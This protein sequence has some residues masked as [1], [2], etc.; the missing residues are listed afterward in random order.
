VIVCARPSV[1]LGFTVLLPATRRSS[2]LQSKNLS[3]ASRICAKSG[4]SSF[5]DDGGRDIV[6]D[7]TFTPSVEVRE[8]IGADDDDDDEAA[9]L[10]YAIDA[11]LR[12]EYDREYA[13]DAPAPHPGLTPCAAVDAALRSLRDLNDPNPS[14]GAA[15]FAR[16]VLPLKRRERWGGGDS[17]SSS[18]S[19]RMKD[20]SSVEDPFKEVLRGALTPSMLARRIR[21]STDFSGLLDWTALEVTE[22]V[23]GHA[24]GSDSNPTGLFDD[25][26]TV[27]YVNAIL[28]FDSDDVRRGDERSR[29]V[30]PDIIQFTLKLF[31]GVWLIDT[32]RKLT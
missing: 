5:D 22:G 28:S 12:G 1:L 11:F 29:A 14:H 31:G 30:E 8:G 10:G 9:V 16:F 6:Y 23:D 32:A 20:G 21:A 18:S 15:V 24:D 13:E 26:P 17:S 7:E 4:E 25:R 3:G 19:R 2:P 27:A